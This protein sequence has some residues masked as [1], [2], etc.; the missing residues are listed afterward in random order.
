MFGIQST[1]VSLA[2]GA[3]STLYFYTQYLSAQN[4]VLVIHAKLQTSEQ[5]VT[6]QKTALQQQSQTLD[7]FKTLSETAQVQINNLTTERDT[8]N[9]KTEQAIQ[10][11]EALRASEKK[12]ALE[13]PYARGNLAYDRIND[14]LQR[15]AGKADTHGRDKNDP[16]VARS[17]TIE[18]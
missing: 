3:A 4:E 9:A 17:G 10:D 18:N 7:T 15:I 8:A 5:L 11:I 13:N 14:S 1:L 6:T 16:S 12:L 2:I